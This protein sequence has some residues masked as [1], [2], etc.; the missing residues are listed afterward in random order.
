MGIAERKEREKVELK[1]RIMGAARQLFIEKGFENTSMRNIANLIEY[2]PGTIYHYFKDKGEIFHALHA[3]GFMELGRRMEVLNSVIDPMERLKAMGK[4]YYSYGL[5]NPEMYNLMFIEVA[6]VEFLEDEN[7]WTEGAIVHGGLRKTVSE[8]IDAGHFTGHDLEPL[9]YMIWSVVHGMVALKIRRR[10]E[11][12]PM[13]QKED[14]VE[15]A[16]SSFL[17]ILDDL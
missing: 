7:N 4:T 13:D 14:I 2:S 6:P 5:E 15:R 17:K 9:T 1:T 12:V 11:V 3:E 16:Y 8:C 10:C